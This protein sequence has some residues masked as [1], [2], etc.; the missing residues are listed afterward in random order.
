M[1]PLR[2]AELAR[3]ATQRFRSSVTWNTEMFVYELERVG[4]Q[5]PNRWN[6]D[7]LNSLSNDRGARTTEVISA[8]LDFY[9]S[10]AAPRLSQIVVSSEVGIAVVLAAVFAWVGAGAGI[11][12]A[13]TGDI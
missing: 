12:V 4:T 9:K 5:K 3:L 6:G 13:T 8:L 1:Q 7:Y 2:G 10:E 11:G